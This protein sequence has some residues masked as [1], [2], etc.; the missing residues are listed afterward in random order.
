MFTIR[1][2]PRSRMCGHDGLRAVE[3]AG[4]VDPQVALPELRRLLVELRGMVERAGVVDEDV[5]RA[6]LLD[7]ARDRGVDLGAVRD[8]AANG[9]RP[10]AHAAISRT[11]SSVCTSPCCRATVASA[12]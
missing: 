2:Q 10:S 11:V 8:V 5:D 6:E 3:R 4:Q 7:R 9:E 1:P 12:P